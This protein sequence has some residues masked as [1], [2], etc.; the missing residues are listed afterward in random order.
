[1]SEE[2][3]EIKA[4]VPKELKIR[5]RKTVL[6][7][8]LGGE[9]LSAIDVSGLTGISRQTVQKSIEHFVNNEM[10]VPV[11]K[12]NSGA[13]GGKRPELYVLNP[14]RFLLSIQN[15]SK[16]F[17][18]VLTNLSGKEIKSMHFPL[19]N[20]IGSEDIY[21]SIKEASNKLLSKNEF[22]A[23]FGVCY[24]LGGIIDRK[25]GKIRFNVI[26][27][28]KWSKDELD[29]RKL[30]E[31]FPTVNYVIVENDARIAAFATLK[32]F[33]EELKEKQAIT[34]FVGE[35]IAGGFFKEG[36]MFFGTHSLVG[37]IGHIVID[38]SDDET[39]KC[40]NRGCL[41]RIVSI[42]RLRTILYNQHERLKK[43][44]LKDIPVEKIE[45]VDIF[46]ASE[47]GDEL[48]RE[49]SVFLG[50][51]FAAAI[52]TVFV[53]FDPEIIIFQGYFAYADHYFKE[54]LLSDI[55]EFL[56]YPHDSKLEILFDKRSW[57]E[58]ETLGSVAALINKI[59]ADEKLY[60]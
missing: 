48:C 4:A 24:S 47:M 12:G 6:S 29:Y 1:M 11:G 30:V 57:E 25:T 58:V 45:Y 20:C 21:R 54:A 55:K 23:L 15:R 14:N 22:E 31:F 10:L 52:K 59:T 32:D 43:S 44:L 46:N 36:E 5:N 50:K 41:E 27:I 53:T 56:Y 9:T 40:G 39:C 18:L 33:H 13:L 7:A 28:S 38:P 2:A 34:I 26:F 8:F 3:K 35:G 60:C 19:D 37:E 16:G 17:N 49:I 51:Q 42:E